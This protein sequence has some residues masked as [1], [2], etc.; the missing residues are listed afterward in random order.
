VDLLGSAATNVTF[1]H[2]YPPRPSTAPTYA[3]IGSA[4]GVTLM[5]TEKVSFGQYLKKI[6]GP[7]AAGFAG[8]FG[9]FLALN[10]AGL[11]PHGAAIV[12]SAHF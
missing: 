7:A 1:L 5:V 9:A 3:A 6:S 8:G 4:A 12:A 2:V 10:A 11:S